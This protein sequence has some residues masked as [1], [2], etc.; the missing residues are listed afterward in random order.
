VIVREL[1]NLENDQTLQFALRGSGEQRTLR[2]I[3]RAFAAR[4]VVTLE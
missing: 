4:G 1:E 2:R 3:L